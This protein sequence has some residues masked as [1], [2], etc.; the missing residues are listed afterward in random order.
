M[1]VEA[2]IDR[3]VL[4]EPLL[5]TGIRRQLAARLASEERGGREAV[6]S[7]RTAMLRKMNAG[8]IAEATDAANEQHYEVQPA[9]YAAVLGP[10]RKYSCGLWESE[11]DGLAATERRM[12]EA[13]VER[14][15]L[16]DGQ[17]ILDLGCGWGSL[18]LYLAEALPRATVTA[19]SNSASQVATIEAMAAERSL[20]NLTAERHD[21]NSFAPGRQFDRIVSV[22]MFEHMRNWR[23]LLEHIAGWLRPGGLAFVHHFAH[24]RFVYPFAADDNGSWMAQHF[25]TGGMMP[26]ADLLARFDRH[27][28]VVGAWDV[29]GRHYQRTCEAWLREMGR[30]R[31]AVE[32]AL[33]RTYGA[34]DVRRWW[35]RWRVFFL[36]CAELF[37]YRDGREWIVAH[38][39]LARTADLP[40]AARA[41]SELPS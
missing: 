35:R 33:A 7:R 10:W 20:H 21:V 29:N 5:R 18:S 36:A 4:P 8:P 26:S 16:A 19:V 34:E 41:G 39:L 37:G 9:F 30:N 38:R 13:Y 12:L 31:P 25:F 40:R 17:A 2:L 24:R 14:A 27:L 6:E 1:W 22:E 3:G 32:R 15:R 11:G 28:T 23:T